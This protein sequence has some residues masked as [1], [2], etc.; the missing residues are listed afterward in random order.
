M[1]TKKE[2]KEEVK[3]P[4]QVTLQDLKDERA[5]MEQATAEAQKAIAEMKDMRAEQILSG[6]ADAAIPVEKPKEVTP[7][8][9][10][11]KVLKG[12]IVG[13]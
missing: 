12:E 10:A 4:L 2:I 6:K 8:E 1:E 11:N 13:E 3:S 9:Y 7:A 5:A